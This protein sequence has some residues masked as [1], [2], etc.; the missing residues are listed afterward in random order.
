VEN[1]VAR[2]LDAIDRAM[3]TLVFVIFLAIVVV[4]TLQVF[5]R[6]ALNVSLSW[7]EEFQRYGQIWIVFLGIPIAYRRGAHI[8]LE[9]LHARLGP[10]GRRALAVVIEL[11]W[12][13]LAVAILIGTWRLMAFLQFQ[14]SPGLGLRMDW[15]Y[16]GIL[17][18]ALYTV[19]VA[20]RRLA[21]HAGLGEAA[22]GPQRE[23]VE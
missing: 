22:P 19:L 15:V 13:G 20:A 3:E 23:P 8:G 5:N 4:G 18:G 2:I 12:I 1:G 16:G 11:L 17:G 6:F 9:M 10:A 14:R 21:A 7:S